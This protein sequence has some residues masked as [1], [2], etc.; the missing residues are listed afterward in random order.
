ML[1]NRSGANSIRQKYSVDCHKTLWD[2]RVLL[3]KH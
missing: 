1:R 3:G 2:Y